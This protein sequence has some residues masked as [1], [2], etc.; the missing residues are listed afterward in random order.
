MFADAKGRVTELCMCI[1]TT[2]ET[3]YILPHI[4]AK[5]R[6]RLIFMQQLSCCIFTLGRSPKRSNGAKIYWIL[7]IPQYESG[8]NTQVKKTPV[9]LRKPF[10]MSNYHLRKKYSH[11]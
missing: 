7:D 2:C 4:H 3:I 6:G 1:F 11:C 10:R 5:G 8:C 9:V